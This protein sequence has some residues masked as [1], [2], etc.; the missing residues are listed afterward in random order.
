MSSTF[1]GTLDVSI[2]DIQSTEKQSLSKQDPYCVLTLGSSGPKSLMEGSQWGKD[3]WKT[4][5]HNGGGQHPVWN[6]S[7]TFNLKNM[8]LD[9]HLKVKLY[10]KDTIKDDYL[11]V[12][13]INLEELLLHDK[14]G[15]K[16]Y[17]LFKKTMMTKEQTPLGQVGIAAT[18]NCTEI[19]QRSGDMKSQVGDVAMRKEQQY[20]GV[21]EPHQ[22]AKPYM[23]GQQGMQQGQMQQGFPQQTGT[24]FQGQDQSTVPSQQLHG[25]QAKAGQQIQGTDLQGQ[26][27]YQKGQLQGTDLQG[28]QAQKGQIQG[29]HGQG[30]GY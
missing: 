22:Q 21:S 28:Q 15:V 24:H 2:A 18:F 5:V 4:K 14:Q 11:G 3:T 1:N 13:T 6:E 23:Q 12:A 10:D 16:Y 29:T 7:H 19:P 27:G 25:T 17:P 30:Q 20:A 9:S 8:K 26:Q